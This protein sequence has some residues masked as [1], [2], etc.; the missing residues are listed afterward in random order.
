MSVTIRTLAPAGVP[1]TRGMIRI[2]LIG[3]MLAAGC[4]VDGRHGVVVSGPGVDGRA[5]ASAVAGLREATG[6]DTDLAIVDACDGRYCIVVVAVQNY[7]D[8]DGT[9]CLGYTNRPGSEGVIV[10]VDAENGNTAT[11]I[12]HELLHAVGIAAHVTGDD[13]GE[14]MQRDQFRGDVRDFGPRTAALYADAFGVRPSVT[15]AF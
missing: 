6:G 12:A 9:K 1:Y 8:P 3:L 15:V 11:V 5:V 7:H 2:T 14:L 13:D 4:A 10:H